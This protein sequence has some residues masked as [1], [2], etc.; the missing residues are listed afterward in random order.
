MLAHG[1]NA[2]AY[3]ILNPGLRLWFGA[4]GDAVIG[5]VTHASTRVVAGAP[6]CAE[7][8][9]PAVIDEFASEAR[10]AGEAVLYFGAGARLERLYTGSPHHAR[11]PLGAQ[12]WWRP[13]DWP[14]ATAMRA[15]LRAQLRRAH[16]KGVRVHEWPAARAQRHPALCS[17]LAEWLTTRGL[18]PLHFLVESDTLGQLADRRVFVATRADD[19]EQV[20]AFLV[21]TPIPARRAWL[22]EQWPRRRTAPNGTV[23]LLVDAA[24]R[25]LHAAGA[26]AV[27]MGLAPLSRRAPDDTPAPAWL[28]LTMRWARAHGRRFYDF[29][30]LDAFKAKFRPESWEPIS[31]IVDE[32]RFTPRALWAVGGAF[33]GGSPIALAAR[34]LSG[35]AREEGRRL[36]GHVTSGAGR[37]PSSP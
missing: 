22:L 1:W 32:P 8:R 35:A 20:V 28:A 23:E 37:A 25:A 11:V 10:R 31:A 21:A 17:V 9:L 3:Q 34:A 26:D 6:V 13:A 5:Y 14:A 18:P 2:V 4:A 24:M 15:S 7:P 16:N 33:G 19:A 36:L 29:D 27:T 12:P 30:G